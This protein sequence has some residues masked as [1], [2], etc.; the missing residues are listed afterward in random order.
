M[1]EYFTYKKV[2]KHQAEKKVHT[3]AQVRTP[4]PQGPS[5]LLNDEDENFLERIVS[6]E[7]TPPPLPSRPMGWA[8][9]VGIEAGDST[10]NQSQ[11]VVHNGNGTMHENNRN[12]KGKG[13]ETI[14]GEKKP[15]RFASFLAKTGPK[16]VFCPSIALYLYN[17]LIICSTETH[18]QLLFQ[19]KPRKKKTTSIAYL[20]TSI[21]QQ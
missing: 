18:K 5:P 8:P 21:L 12:H 2:K 3:P 10:G 15:G 17:M 7:G 6:A 13:R 1:L 11:M 16:K 20:K 9:G 4:T 14:D 19:E